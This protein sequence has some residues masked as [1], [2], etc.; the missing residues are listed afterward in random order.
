MPRMESGVSFTS[1]D[2]DGDDRFQWL[3]RELGVSTFGLSL[4]RLRPGQRGRIHRHLHQEEA[5]LVLEGTLTLLIEDEPREL[6]HGDLARVGPEVRRQLVNRGPERVLLIAMGGAHAPREPRRP[7]LHVVGRGGRGSPAAGGPDAG[8]PPRMKDRMLRGELYIADDPELAADH[9]R[10]G[11]LLERYNRHADEEQEERDRLL[12]ELLGSVGDGV[13]VRPPFR[14]DYGDPITIGDGTFVNYDCIV[15]DVAPITIGADC[16]IA[17]RVQLLT[18]THPI[19]PGRAAR[20][21]EYSEPITIGDNVWLGGGVI[22]CPGVTIG[23]DTVVGAGA[24][25]TR[26]LPAG[27]V[28]AGVPATI[29]REIG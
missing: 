18:A 17:T 15:L 7:R 4:I 6:R 13:V 20:G 25:V 23:D 29:K 12:R 28:A 9:Y 8:R 10:A 27:V 3:R 21:W 16:Q 5:Y 11:T 19:D 14:C 2:P 26:D 24:V 22:V 1:L